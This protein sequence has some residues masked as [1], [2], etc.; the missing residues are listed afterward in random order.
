MAKPGKSV[1][2]PI[3]QLRVILK[4]IKPPIWRRILIASDVK[5]HRLHY[6][7]Q[8]VMGWDNSH[9]YQ[10]IVKD[11][12][13][14]HFYGEPHDDYGGQMK[15]A[16]R[17]RL[18]EVA[19][20]AKARLVYEYDFGDD[21]EHEIL[22]EKIVP[23]EAGLKYPVCISGARACPPEDCGGTWGYGEFLKAIADPDNPE[24]ESTLEWTGD[25]F[26]FDPEQF[27]LEEVNRELGT[28]RWLR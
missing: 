6:I 17:V 9:L 13:M 28:G 16:R 11:G 25:G 18:S 14:R 12:A 26:D 23:R 3:Y 1:D 27:D 22:V 15:D 24:S 20:G 21:W 19:P 4:D 8:D 2:T 7:L 5:L 10:F